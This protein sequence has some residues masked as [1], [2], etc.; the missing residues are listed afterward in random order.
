MLFESD[1]DE[2]FDLT[3]SGSEYMSENIDFSESDDGISDI[4]QNI[5]TLKLSF[6]LLIMRKKLFGM[7]R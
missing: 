4:E 3:D 1:S 7:M 2:N 6:V 5:N